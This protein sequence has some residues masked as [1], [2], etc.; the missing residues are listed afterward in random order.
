MAKGVKLTR[1]L[2]ATEPLAS[3]V[4]GELWPGP[5]VT[6]DDQRVEAVLGAMNTYAH[7]TSTCAMG[8]AGTRWAVVDQRGAVH[9][10]DGLYVID[11]S[12]FPTIP[13]VPTNQTTIMLAER[14]AARVREAL[15]VPAVQS[16]R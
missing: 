16:A 3:Y 11:A 4:T 5:D 8:P 12:I 15:A 14:C 7:A 10:L 9:G 13:S 1:E 2:L 6:S